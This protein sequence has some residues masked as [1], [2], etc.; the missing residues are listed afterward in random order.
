M[1]LKGYLQPI[2]L[3][4]TKSDVWVFDQLFVSKGY[5]IHVPFE[6]KNVIDGGANIGLSAV[7]LSHKYPSAQIVAIEPD[8]EN[9]EMIEKNTAMYPLVTKLKRG[10]WDKECY[11]NIKQAPGTES[12]AFETEEATVP[13]KNSIHSITIDGIMEKMGW[14]Y[15]DILKIDIE[16][17]E[18]ALFAGDVSKWLPKVKVIFIELHEW[19]QP[20]ITQLFHEVIKPYGF[21]VYKNRENLICIR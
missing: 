6:V 15:I 1:H 3:R 21:S 19:L 12:W 9:F 18:K 16:G 5:D 11:L 10:L 7:F 2:H 8:T 4:T 17:A 13:S 14:D 20:G